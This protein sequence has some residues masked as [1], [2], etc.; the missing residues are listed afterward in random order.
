MCVLIHKILVASFLVSVSW[1]PGKCP[2]GS[3]GEGPRPW[4]QPPPNPQPSRLPPASRLV[5][6]GCAATPQDAAAWN[7]EEEHLLDICW[8]PLANLPSFSPA[9]LE[10]C[11]TKETS[12]S[13]LETDAPEA[14]GWLRVSP[15]RIAQSC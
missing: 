15:P 3:G 2:L 5:P 11:Q 9:R 14:A 13:A 8:N 6:H 10:E 1:S 4:F 7:S 12:R